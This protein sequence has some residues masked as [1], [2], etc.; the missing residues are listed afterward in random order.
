MGLSCDFDEDNESYLLASSS[1][2]I[3]FTVD[4]AGSPKAVKVVHGAEEEEDDQKCLRLL[5]NGKAW[6]MDSAKGALFNEK[7]R[8]NVPLRNNHHARIHISMQCI[9]H[10]CSRG[11]WQWDGVLVPH[12]SSAPVLSPGPRSFS[13]I[14]YKF[15]FV[16]G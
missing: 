12:G 3:E 16:Y 10:C 13:M 15:V 7:N 8:H 2:Y 14:N 11:A 6:V 1:F 4:A 5:Q 9:P